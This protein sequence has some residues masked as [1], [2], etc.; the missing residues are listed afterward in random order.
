MPTPVALAD[1]V[2]QRLRPRVVGVP[3]RGHRAL[4]SERLR[5][6]AKGIELLPALVALLDVRPDQTKGDAGEMSFRILEQTA[7][8]N[9]DTG[10]HFES[11]LSNCRNSALP[12]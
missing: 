6:L 4:I 12:R 9:I 3:I 10:T 1:R 7:M 11:P 8:M 2:S 5:Q